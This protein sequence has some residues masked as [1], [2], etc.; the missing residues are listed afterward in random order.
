MRIK[1]EM[2]QNNCRDNMN[3]PVVDERPSV[4]G[5]SPISDFEDADQPSL[6]EMFVQLQKYAYLTDLII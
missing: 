5:F 6:P 2:E 1:S 4:L 3:T